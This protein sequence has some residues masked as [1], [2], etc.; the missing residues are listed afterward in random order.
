MATLSPAEI[1]KYAIGAG[2]TP[3]EAVTM[4]AIAMSESGGRTT[5]H[6]PNGEDS[7]GLW[8]INQQA[9]GFSGNLYDPAQN[10]AA[11]YKVY[12]GSGRSI[13]PW[14]VTHKKNNYMYTKNR[15]AAEQAARDNGYSTAQGNWDGSPGY[16]HS[17]SASGGSGTTANEADTTQDGVAEAE[18]FD[19]TAPADMQVIK[20]GD[21]TYVA[22]ELV[23][24]VWAYFDGPEVD[25][26]Q[27]L[28]VWEVTAETWEVLTTIR[29]GD[30]TELDDLAGNFDSFGE[31]FDEMMYLAGFSEE[32]MRDPSVV[33]LL[34]EFT[35][36]PDMQPAEVQRRLQETDWYNNTTDVARQWNDLGNADKQVE[37]DKQTDAVLKALFQYAGVT[38]DMTDPK[39]IQWA[40]EIASGKTTLTTLINSTIKPLA[41]DLPDSPWARTIRDEERAQRQTGVDYENEAGRARALAHRWGVQLSDSEAIE[42]GRKITEGIM[43][44]NDLT[45]YVKDVAQSLYPWK[46]REQ[47]TMTAAQPYMQTYANLMEVPTPD[48][49]DPV[50]QRAMQQGQTTTDFAEQ[51][52]AS[53]RWLTTKNAEDDLTAIG[54]QVGRLM[55]FE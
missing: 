37:I 29:I 17:V 48:I 24:G 46:S 19:G 44:Q 50:I 54:S 41:Q 18:A 26:V 23:D 47:E 28:P 14:T 11:A 9:H 8:Q 51:M 7:Q 25:K 15:A 42:W 45:E 35:A 20:V 31:F 53:D 34:A 38:G 55:G 1:Y 27:G 2:F 4:T 16:G 43:S 21:K 6:N 39:I 12:V 22:K 36:R 32:A 3:D 5:A 30:V 49:F 52:R 40:E 33:A 10:A 13:S